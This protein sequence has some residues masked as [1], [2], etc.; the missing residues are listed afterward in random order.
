MK[1]EYKNRYGD[2]HTFTKTED[3]NIL[4]EGNFEYSRRGWPNVYTEAYNQYVLDGGDMDLKQF[5]KEVHE[6]VYDENGKY[7][8][9]SETS[10]KYCKLVYSDL[11]TIDFADPSGGP[12]ISSNM[13]MGRF[14]EEFKGMIVEK[15]EQVK[16]GYKIIIKK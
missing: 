13:D 8:H 1:V 3:G 9:M 6:A 11:N 4:W 12:Y 15:F 16:T 2:V 10:Q 7:L 14:D 5:K